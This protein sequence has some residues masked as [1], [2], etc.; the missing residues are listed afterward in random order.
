MALSVAMIETVALLAAAC[1]TSVVWGLSARAN[2]ADFAAVLRESAA[3]S[4]CC[5]VSFYYNDLYDLRLVRGF[6]DFVPRLGRS[7]AATA[8]IV[9]LAAPLLPARALDAALVATLLVMV[10][11][12]VVPLRA[13]SYG[14]ITHSRP[15]AERVVI[16]G[17][18]PLA[19]NIA[20][21]IEASPHLGYA[22]SA[23]IEEGPLDPR[24]P[25]DGRFPRHGLA[26]LCDVVSRVR[27]GYIVSAF[28]ERRG[29]MPVWT[30][31]ASCATG[32]RVMDGIQFYERITQKLAI[33]SLS[34][35]AVIFSEMLPK[36]RGRMAV[37]R[38]VNVL[39]AAAG[40]LLAAP[41]MALIA[42][43][44][45]LESPGGALFV[46]ER[47]GRGG[48]TFPLLKFRTMR[49]DAPAG[50]VWHRDDEG[51][52]TAVGRWLRQWR[53]DELP[54]FLNI[55]RGDMNLIGPRPEMACNVAAMTELIPYYPLRHAVRPGVTGWA[56]IR[57]GYS[58]TQ[59]EVTEKVRYDLY[60]IKHMSLW[61]DLRILADTVKIVVFGR[62]AR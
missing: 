4:L 51:R 9:V 3:L 12:L 22:V 62:W 20:E 43:L 28:T 1:L 27:P 52:V 39:I 40:L 58:V 31:L 35:S 47:T 5:M 36:P 6:R 8:V 55:L 57:Q 61:L 25:D 54:Q 42:L 30:L 24:L 33:E 21:E 10:V 34:P 41:L 17:T 59:A 23:L 48:R 44:V 2:P 38:A 26:E 46:Q 29:R 56:Q 49:G 18:S 32:V 60:Y 15:L 14:L 45:R 50:D 19:L 37:R 7:L 16:L 53:L 11:A 13:I